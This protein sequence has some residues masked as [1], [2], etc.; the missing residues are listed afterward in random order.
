MEARVSSPGG[1]GQARGL[2][3]KGER[4]GEADSGGIQAAGT[5]CPIFAAMAVLRP[6]IGAG[7]VTVKLW[8]PCVLGREIERGQAALTCRPF[9]TCRTLEAGD[10]RPAIV[11]AAA[12]RPAHSL[13][14]AAPGA[15][16]AGAKLRAS[17]RVSVS[18]SVPPSVPRL[19]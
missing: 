6:S 19:A 2:L 8:G 10:G 3:L 18:D 17:A 12:R 13:G 7:E 14:R 4:W 11:A 5:R 16:R 1:H 15:A 9:S